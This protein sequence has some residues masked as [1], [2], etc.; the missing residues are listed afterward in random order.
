MIWKPNEPA[1]LGSRKPVFPA[2]EGV[3]V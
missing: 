3:L 2:G 1:H